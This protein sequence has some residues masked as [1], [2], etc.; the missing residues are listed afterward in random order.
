VD[1]RVGHFR[2][3][4]DAN[5]SVLI[6]EPIRIAYTQCSGGGTVRT[7]LSL[8]RADRDELER[9]AAECVLRARPELERDL[10]VGYKLLLPPYPGFL[11]G[12]DIGAW[13]D[14]FRLGDEEFF[15]HQSEKRWAVDDAFRQGST[16]LWAPPPAAD[17]TRLA[18]SRQV[19]AFAK[20]LTAEKTGFTFEAER[21]GD[22]LLIRATPV[23]YRKTGGV[24]LVL[25]ITPEMAREDRD[26]FCETE[27]TA[28]YGA[29][30]AGAPATPAD[31]LFI[32]Y[33]FN[34]YQMCL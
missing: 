3:M 29:D 15:F 13:K 22:S 9:A 31:P 20:D 27:V 16:Y 5:N 19:A 32:P 7:D 17:G 24:S 1:N 8:S 6:A 4:P 25:K 34:P 23:A 2:A 10:R 26:S 14:L 11:S 21:E 30:K 28:F 12:A 33:S 18:P